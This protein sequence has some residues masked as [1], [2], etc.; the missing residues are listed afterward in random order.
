M[1]KV[2]VHGVGNDLPERA[3]VGGV[4]NRGDIAR[5]DSE[6]ILVADDVVEVVGG[7]P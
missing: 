3:Q 5:V 7:L 6:R 2:A 4:A 1:A